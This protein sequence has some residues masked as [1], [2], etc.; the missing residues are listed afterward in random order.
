MVRALRMAGITRVVLV[1][2][3]RADIADMVGRIVGVDII[4]DDGKVTTVYLPAKEAVTN[5]DVSRTHGLP[6]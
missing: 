5:Q 3:D 6:T 1:T 2:G 4:Q